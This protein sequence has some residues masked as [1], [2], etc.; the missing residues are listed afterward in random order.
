MG[1]TWKGAKVPNLF[2]FFRLQQEKYSHNALCLRFPGVNAM[3]TLAT[4]IFLLVLT[5][6]QRSINI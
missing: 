5:F 1:N 3:S 4:F 2:A 6:I